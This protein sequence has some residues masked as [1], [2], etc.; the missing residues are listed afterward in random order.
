[1]V[2]LYLFLSTIALE[3]V[4]EQFGV[5]YLEYKRRVPRFVHIGKSIQTANQKI[6]LENHRDQ[7][8]QH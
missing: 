4:E 3:L 1:M 2:I 7:H 8:V 6:S 5:E